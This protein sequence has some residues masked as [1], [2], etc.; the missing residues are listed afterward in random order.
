MSA[1]RP[2]T[3][4]V[5]VAVVA[6]VVVVA[7]IAVAGSLIGRGGPEQRTSESSGAS[8]SD[9]G[10]PGSDTTGP[11]ATQPSGASGTGNGSTTGGPASPTATSATGPTTTLVVPAY[12]LGDGARGTRLFRE[13]QRIS[14]GDPL[15]GALLALQGRPRDPDYRTPWA[16]GSFASAHFDGVGAGGTISLELADPALTARPPGT[17]PSEA[18]MAV[19]QVVHTL[20]AAVQARARVVVFRGGQQLD[21]LYGVPVGAGLANAP[22]LEVLS[23]MSI[24]APEEGAVVRGSF[25]ASGVGSS[26][27]ANVPW[28]I[29]RGETT[30]KSGFTTAAGWLDKLYP[31]RTGPIDVSDLTPGR[32]TFLAS[33]DDPSAGEAGAEGAGPEIDTRTIVVR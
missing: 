1:R 20:Q 21:A 2:W 31:W 6:T 23:L 8:P 29:R 32:Y 28:E 19:Q 26:F 16:E 9:T 25:R 7:G 33:T 3:L 14:A 12:Y 27:E 10:T 5:G 11:D 22:A 15:E 24:T 17:S 18:R 13:F 30:V 4:A